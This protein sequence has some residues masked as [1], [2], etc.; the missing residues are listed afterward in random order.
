[1]IRAR[2]GIQP[3]Q[4]G[5]LRGTLA[6]G[7][8]HR[9]GDPVAVDQPLAVTRSGRDPGHAVRGPADGDHLAQVELGRAGHDPVRLPPERQHLCRG[10]RIVGGDRCAQARGAER[11]PDDRPYPGRPGEDDLGASTAD[12]DHGH[13]PV[14][15]A[16]G[17]AE[18]GQRALLGLFE[19]VDGDVSGDLDLVGRPRGVGGVAQRIGPG[20]RDGLC[21]EPS[22]LVGVVRQR[23]RQLFSRLGSEQAAGLDPATQAEQLGHVQDRLEAPRRDV[24]DQQVDR[25]GADVD[26]G[27]PACLAHAPSAGVWSRSASFMG[28]SGELGG[29]SPV[30]P[31]SSAGAEPSSG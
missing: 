13:V 21:T 16:A 27:R 9:Q 28:P 12:V 11:Q 8:G 15:R 14:G 17:H 30:G 26:G 6:A 7:D 19:D 29:A 31:A 23:S 2:R 4:L 5:D 1:M 22:G 25:G 3:E 24:G 10:G 20:E 18:Q